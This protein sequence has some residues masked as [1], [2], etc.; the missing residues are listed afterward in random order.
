MLLVVICAYYVDAEVKN[1]MV[2]YVVLTTASILF[3]LITL[4]FMPQDWQ[5][6]TPGQAFTHGLFMV[7]LILKFLILGTIYLYEKENDGESSGWK[8]MAP[9]P[10]KGEEDEIAE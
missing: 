5:V 8:Q 2:M 7:V 6:Y 4:N 10:E 9:D 3:D 1:F